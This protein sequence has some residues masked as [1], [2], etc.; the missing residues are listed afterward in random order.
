M[1]ILAS[2]PD[3]LGDMV[4]RQPLYAALSAA[5]HELTLIV[6]PTVAPLVPYVAP[7]A[8]VLTLPTEVY[9]DDL[10]RH[11]DQFQE[12]FETVR[13]LEPDALLVAPFRWTLF[14]EKLA[15]ELPR[16]PRYGM[17]GRL[18]TGDPHAGHP[19]VSRLRFDVVAQVD[20]NRPEIEKYAA[21][22]SEVLGELV[23]LPFP[24]LLPDEES[25]ARAS[26]ILGRLNLKASGFW[27]A[28][29][30]GTAHVSLKRWP[31]DSWA[32]V[33]SHWSQNHDRR[34]LFVGL[35][36]ERQIIDAV[37]TAMGSSAERSQVWAEPGSSIG[38][39]LALTALS[40]GYAGHDTG[41]M[42][43]AAATGKPV[44]AVFGGGTWPRFVPAVA[45]SCAI[46]VGV[47]CAGC[48]W[49][50]GFAR[51]HCIE[52]VPTHEVKRAV[53]DLEN[54]T[55]TGREVRVLSAADDLHGRMVREAAELVR[56]QAR[57]VGEL[58]R[59]L[60]DARQQQSVE[61]AH[62]RQEFDQRL[63]QIRTELDES[64]RARRREAESLRETISRLRERITA[65]EPKPKP[66]KLPWKLRVAKW[67]AGPEYY[68]PWRGSRE[69]P[70]I[71]LVTPVKNGRQWIRETIES[72][73]GQNYPKLEY[74]IV[75]GGSTDGT[76]QI[77][78]EYR[79]R[80][81]KIIS[82]PDEGMYDAIGK[83]F[84]LARGDVLGYLNADDVLE[85]GGLLRVGEYFRDH[86]RAKVIYHEDTVT[87]DG[88]R[89]PNFP[90][91]HAD[92]YALLAGHTLYQDGIFFRRSA[93]KLAGGINRKL[94]RA[95]DWDLW[96]RMARMFGLKRVA[97]H[98]SSF[99]VRDGQISQDRAAYDAELAEARDAFLRKFGLPGRVR[100]QV[101]HAFNVV[102]NTLERALVRRKLFWPGDYCGKPFPPG[103]A[104]P[105]VPGQP[106]CPL[107][108]QAPDRLLFSTRDTRFGDPRIHYVYYD[109]QSEMAM[110]HPPMSHQQL[111]DL[112]EKHYS[113]PLTQVIEPDPNYHSP[114]RN[115]RGGNIITRNLSRIPSP[116]WWFH[117]VTYHDTAAEE[118]L[119]SVRDIAAPQSP[120]VRFLD[121]GCFEGNLLDELKQQTKWQ[122]FGLEANGKAVEAARA[123][124]H[125][126]WQAAAEDAPLLVPQDQGFDVIYLGQ[127]MEHLDDPLAA[128]TRLRLL[129]A[130]GGAILIS[131][132]NLDSKQVEFFGPTWA[133]WHLPYHRTLLSRRALRRMAKL[134]GMRVERLRTRTHTYWTTMSVQLNRLGL[135]AVVPHSAYFPNV[136]S[137]H[138]VR[139][140][141]WARLLWDWRGRGDYL[142]AVLHDLPAT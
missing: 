129:L 67:I 27:I 76:L 48:G 16:I 77:L 116:W 63:A 111:N 107:T 26:E 11:W 124:G 70:K 89:F 43:I 72:V 93:Y 47:P 64:V 60:D 62:I 2:N 56:T 126:V 18:Y 32:Q 13:K 128:L 10:P 142:F 30:A 121:V 83:G 24:S 139:L 59:T 78:E 85:P 25:L 113:K 20:E 123:K 52:A 99:R 8:K 29:V 49:V 5:G 65:L 96:V 79:D 101:I 38:D 35:P 118:I 84:D 82:E 46:T 81:T 88:W 133:H 34:F 104:P 50:C 53:N 41:P 103:D 7:Q 102:R 130:P 3:T 98:V 12:L 36:Q 131:V 119:R 132:P 95:G 22:A 141:G 55:I 51:P 127:T 21:L 69:L 6:R 39:L 45:P 33:L 106:V 40:G 108:G 73:L 19:A 61:L 68:A 71:T 92:V 134:A 75:D 100:C 1:R 105:L 120:D 54:G 135:G 15:D 58:R 137:M 117:E 87:R 110:A 112:Y 57:E 66:P 90:Q 44:L 86:P 31:A 9:R 14:E 94:K 74:I 122:L 28:A 138:G 4:Q 115:Y 23:R 42:H 136:M 17:S 91:P 109:S 125:A 97:G 114:Y 140:T 80:V 37:R